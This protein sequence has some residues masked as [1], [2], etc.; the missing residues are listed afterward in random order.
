MTTTPPTSA[1]DDSDYLARVRAGEPGAYAE[2]YRRHYPA[3][4]RA[5]RII[6]GHDLAED[7]VAEAFLNT[8]RVLQRGGGPDRAFRTYVL[9]A[10]RHAHISAAR[11]TNRVFSVDDIT[12]YVPTENGSPDPWLALLEGEMVR[13]AFAS[14]P[15]RWRE[16][17][18]QRE[19]EGRSVSEVG[20]LLGLSSGAVVQLAFRAREGLRLAYLA[21]HTATTDQACARFAAQLPKYARGNSHQR[22][23]ALQ[24]HLDG[25]RDCTAAAVEIDSTAV[26]LPTG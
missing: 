3:V 2:L 20:D 22:T 13:A 17:L 23:I 11:K 7:L 15:Q 18:W 26:L 25:C 24:A 8:F 1:L 14:L 16:V 6:A 10:V 21:Q 9:T 4:L 5:A 12:P 19:V